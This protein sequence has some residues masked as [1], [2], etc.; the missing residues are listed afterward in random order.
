MTNEGGSLFNAGEK[1]G[2]K[3]LT[4]VD[5]LA[6]HFLTQ[7]ESLA[8]YGLWRIIGGEPLGL[9]KFSIKIVLLLGTDISRNKLGVGQPAQ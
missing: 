9:A 4:Q 7:L 3:L 2:K 1:I 5:R 8:T 6:K